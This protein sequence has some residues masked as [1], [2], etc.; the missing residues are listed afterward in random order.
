MTRRTLAA[1][2]EIPGRYALGDFVRRVHSTEA[3]PAHRPRLGYL[4]T[5]ELEAAYFYLAAYPP[6]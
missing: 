4:S 3:R 2:S 5:A 1:L 6:K